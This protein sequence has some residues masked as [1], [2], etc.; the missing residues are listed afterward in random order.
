[1]KMIYRMRTCGHRMGSRSIP[2]GEEIPNGWYDSPEV[3]EVES[4]KLQENRRNEYKELLPQATEILEQK[5]LELLEAID[6]LECDVYTSAEA[7]DDTGLDSWLTIE[8][9]LS[10]KFGTYPY[11]SDIQI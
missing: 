6:N 8:I 9:R 1:M 4:K 11:S 5:K 10:G 7:L 2:V 3:A